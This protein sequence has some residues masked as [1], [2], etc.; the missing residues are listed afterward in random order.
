MLRC[1]FPFLLMSISSFMLPLTLLRCCL[2]RWRVW[3]VE[4]KSKLRRLS[5]QFTCLG[6]KDNLQLR[7]PH[8]PLPPGSPRA[9]SVLPQLPALPL[10]AFFCARALCAR[11]EFV[12]FRQHQMQRVLQIHKKDSKRQ[13]GFKTK[14]RKMPTTP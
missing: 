14:A 10:A 3:R 12:N 4:T 7:C 2:W 1:H 8:S 13:K 5:A 11:A 6:T 9:G